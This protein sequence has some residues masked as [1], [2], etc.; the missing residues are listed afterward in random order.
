MICLIIDE[1]EQ[2]V[3]SLESVEGFTAGDF[4]AILEE[5]CVQY[6]GMRRITDNIT[7]V[8]SYWRM[9]ALEAPVYYISYAVSLTEALNIYAIACED[10]AKA[11]E[12]YKFIVED[13][14]P[15]DG[16]L[17]TLEKA[18]LS[19]PFDEETMKAIADM[20]TP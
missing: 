7:D 15:E 5:V 1:F 4:D 17:I 2:R 20:M 19:S 16:F 6:G 13:A 18:G 14:I 9:I 3:Y 8:Q 10:E 12:V 11:H